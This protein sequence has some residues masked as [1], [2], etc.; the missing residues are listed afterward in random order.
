MKKSICILGGD[1]RN[2]ELAKIL[3]EQG[4]VVKTYDET[5]KENSFLWIGSIWVA[6]SPFKS[7]IFTF[8]EYKAE[9]GE[10]NVSEQEKDIYNS[11]MDDLREI[12]GRVNGYFI[13]AILSIGISFLSMWLGQ[14]G[15]KVKNPSQ[16]SNKIMLF[17]MPIIMGIFSI[18]YN[19]VFAIYLV[20][21]QAISAAITPLSNLIIN[22]WEK[23]DLKK[24]EAKQTVVD[25]RRKW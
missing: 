7:S 21:S 6:D 12:K 15:T 3:R 20:V 13:L 23:H 22:K 11:F 5:Q 10:N 9:I 4:F 24:E 19:S 2:D 18:L 16:K 25:Y 1:S 14:R 8:D 17:I